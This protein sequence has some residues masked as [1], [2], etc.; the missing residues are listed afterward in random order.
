MKNK[1]GVRTIGLFFVVTSLIGLIFSALGIGFLWVIRPRIE[2]GLIDFI[3]TINLTLDNT[4]QSLEIL[5]DVIDLTK[6]NINTLEMTLDNLDGT[7][8]SVSD[9]L[10][11]TAVLVG[12]DLRQTVLDTQIALTSASTS[13]ELIDNTLLFLAA[14]P[15][16]G[17]DYQPDVPLHTS[18]GQV[19]DN[20]DEIPDSLESMEQTLGDAAE[21]LDTLNADL[22]ILVNDIQGFEQDLNDA[23]TVLNEYSN[24]LEQ[25]QEQT[26]TLLEN[27]GLYLVF[28]M[29]FFTGILVWL[30]ITQI[31]ILMQG[32]Q[33][34]HGEQKVVNLADIQRD[35]ED[36]D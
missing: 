25:T 15:F 5:D 7:I 14:I 4:H 33:Y 17:A 22:K 6:L 36:N 1:I 10:E 29:I 18:L 8:V 28:L 16:V 27:L 26:E 12:D 31:N 24:I 34:L 23:Q 30:S 11:T 21:G 19:A 32:W 3:D 9:S 35:S 2:T 13:A 20:L